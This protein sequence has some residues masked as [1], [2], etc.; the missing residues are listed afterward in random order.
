MTGKDQEVVSLCGTGNGA[1]GL[2]LARQTLYYGATTL[3]WEETSWNFI[4]YF[5]VSVIKYSDKTKTNKQV[6]EERIYF[7]F[8]FQRRL[9]PRWW[10]RYAARP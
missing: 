4:S 3:A 5:S 6:K 2:S 9:S 8:K 1:P 7:G 10:K